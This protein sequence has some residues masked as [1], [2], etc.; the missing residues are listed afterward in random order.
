MY[1][2][3]AL[4]SSYPRAVYDRP[5]WKKL[6]E[7]HGGGFFALPRPDALR[8]RPRT[9]FN[10]GWTWLQLDVFPAPIIDCMAWHGI[11]ICMLWRF[12]TG[13]AV[14]IIFRAAAETLHED[15]GGR[16]EQGSPVAT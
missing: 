15:Q 5:R 4:P 10:R 8:V 3:E 6:L 13:A 9:V 1:I 14:W 7:I 16:L 11:C 2:S 12:S